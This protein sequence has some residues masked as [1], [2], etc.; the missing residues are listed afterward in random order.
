MSR[1]R[2]TLLLFFLGWIGSGLTIASREP[3]AVGAFVA[4]IFIAGGSFG[5]LAVVITRPRLRHLAALITEG[6]ELYQSM[7]PG[8]SNNPGNSRINEPA[9]RDWEA[10]V[11]N[12]I[13]PLDRALA[14]T[15]RLGNPE[16]SESGYDRVNWRQFMEVRLG[17]LSEIVAALR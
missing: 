14:E 5:C 15:F 6:Q 16:F 2:I 9:C 3:E 10:R 4:A 7:A 11:Y 13:L 12:V 8:S 1:A 17:R